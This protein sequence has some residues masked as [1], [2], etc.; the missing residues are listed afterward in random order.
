MTANRHSIARAFLAAVY[1]LLCAVGTVSIVSGNISIIAIVLLTLLFIT[2]LALLGKL[3]RWAQRTGLVTGFLYTA[4]G[5][6]GVWLSASRLVAGDRNA[7]PMLTLAIALLALGLLTIF[8]L[9]RDLR[10]QSV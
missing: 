3:G 4:V 7:F 5:I 6:G 1:F 8:F 10:A 2:L 9:L